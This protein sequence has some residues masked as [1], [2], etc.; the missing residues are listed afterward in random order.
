MI[1]IIS[2]LKKRIITII[3]WEDVKNCRI[4]S[5]KLM[6]LFNVCV[7]NDKCVKCKLQ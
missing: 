6:V 4:Q 5:N 1:T 7:S 3:W 2:S